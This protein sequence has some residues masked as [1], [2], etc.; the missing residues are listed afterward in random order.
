[1]C[2]YRLS[3][4]LNKFIQ[5]YYFD[6]DNP[7][8]GNLHVCLDDGNLSESNIAFCQEQAEKDNDSFGI[9]LSR[10]MREFTEEEL[11]ELYEKDWFGMDKEN[12]SF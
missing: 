5:Y 7:A 12:A 9:F 8:G 3:A 1:M 11:E 6:L 2:F 4:F 10:L